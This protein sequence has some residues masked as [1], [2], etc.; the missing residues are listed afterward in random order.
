MEVSP[1]VHFVL[2]RNSMYTNKTDTNT[3]TDT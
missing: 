3:N 2:T 1:P